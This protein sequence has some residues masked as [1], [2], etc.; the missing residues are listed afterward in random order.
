VLPAIQVIELDESHIAL[1]GD[2]C[3]SE[4]GRSSP[5][6]TAQSGSFVLAVNGRLLADAGPSRLFPNMFR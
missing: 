2:I 4:F 1:Q 3:R 5:F 6:A